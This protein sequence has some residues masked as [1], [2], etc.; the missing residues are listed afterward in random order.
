MLIFQQCFYQDLAI[1]VYVKTLINHHKNIVV[2]VYVVHPLEP[3]DQFYD[4]FP[5]VH[6]NYM[7]YWS[8]NHPP[9]STKSLFL[10]KCDFIKRKYKVK[11]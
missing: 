1:R 5:H 10:T 9:T 6:G 4:I 3:I 8:L 11:T 7:S 2:S